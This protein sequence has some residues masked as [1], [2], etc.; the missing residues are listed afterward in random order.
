MR[1]TV[2]FLPFVVLATAIL[3][4]HD[5]QD[6]ARRRF[7]RIVGHNDGRCIELDDG[8]DNDVGTVCSDG[9]TVVICNNDNE[10]V[11]FNVPAEGS[12]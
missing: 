4:C 8:H 11:T 2:A 10:C 9:R 12:R 1:F 5:S 6:T 3:A 7:Q